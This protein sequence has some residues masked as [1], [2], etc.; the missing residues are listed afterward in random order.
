MDEKIKILCVDDEKN[1]LRALQRVFLDEDY[2]LFAAL[3]GPEG[4]EIL[5]REDG[6]QVVISDYRMPD[7]TGVEFLHE[8]C[9]RRPETVRIV[10]SGYADTAAVVDAINEGQIYKFIPKP[11]NDDELRVTIHNAL[12]LYFLHARNRQLMA[13][14]R[15]SNEELRLMNDNLEQMVNERTAELVFRNRVLTGAQNMLHA[16]PLGVI[17][18]DRD[19]QVAYCNDRGCTL[20]DS[21]ENVAMGSDRHDTLPEAIN[22]FIDELRVR[23]SHEGPVVVG[24]VTLYVKG[25]HMVFGEQQGLILTLDRGGKNE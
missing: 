6:I 1:V 19:D 7:M 2:E 13:E 9:R 25:V 10:L 16:L 8:V 14:L 20:C 18:I 4:L 3:S 22:R 17:G 15:D 12:E 11:W 23:E 5:E 21:V 24:G